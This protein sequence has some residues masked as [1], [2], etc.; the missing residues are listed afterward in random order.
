MFRFLHAESKTIIG[1]AAIVGT[2]SFVSR[3]VG[4]I[5]D[6]ILAGT[7]GAGDTLDVYYSA[8]KVPDLMFSLIVVGAISSSFIPIF[9]E[10]YF[11][12]KKENAW[13]F[14][15]TVLHLVGA[16]MVVI[17]ILLFIFSDP[18][19]AL[20]APGFH[21]AK[22]EAVGEFMRVMLFA[23]ILL[24][25]SMV[26]GSVLQ[27][28]K[29]FFLYSLAPIFYNVGIIFGALFL[30]DIFGP[31]GLAWGVVFGAFLHVAS[32][33]LECRRSGYRYEFIIKRKT[34]EISEMIRMTGPRMLGIVVNQLLFFV[35]TII[36]T[37]FAAGS[38]TIFQFAYNIQFFPVGIIGVSF[39]I[40]AFPLFSEQAQQNDLNSFRASFSSTIR[41]TLFF[42]IP[43]MLLFLIL[44]SQIVRV[45]VG[46][47]SF[48]WTATI[49]TADTLAF[50]ALTFIPQ[51]FVFILAR[52]FFALHDS[53][54]PLIAGLVGALV[55]IISAFLFRES[56]G[57]VGLGIAYSLSAIVN[58]VL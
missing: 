19:S 46:A 39:A 43:C 5:R 48:D 18:I 58:A 35:L 51:A 52:A 12:S 14:T 21:S 23:Q 29:Q 55:G 7:F 25:F 32:Q 47:G 41:Q 38:V 24:S 57:V 1:A 15:N 50:F 30:T 44:R 56:F 54:T 6:R 37:T 28:F 16:V 40:A 22:Q 42:L 3:F 9:S 53:V 2:L 26:F 27:S 10:M 49:L 13:K 11:G 36:A 4:F 17:S 8:F 33:W 31:I 20:I 34:T 45:V